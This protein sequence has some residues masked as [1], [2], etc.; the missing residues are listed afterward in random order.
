MSF[1]ITGS[2]AYDY[3]MFY[4]GRYRDHILMDQLDKISLSFLAESMRKERGGVAANIAYTMKL[5]GSDPIVLATV[6]QDFGDYRQ[7]MQE[8]GLRTDHIVEIEDEFTASF[9]VGSDQEQN[10]IAIFYTGAMAHA[11][12]YSL[13]SRGLHDAQIVMISPND[14]GAMLHYAQE[15]RRLGIP[16]AYD[17]S[18]QVPR[19]G[20]EELAQSIPGATYLL[21]NE[22]ELGVIQKKTGWSIDDIRSQVSVFVHTLGKE[23]SLIYS[24][25]LEIRIPAAR[26]DK[27]VDPTGAGDAYRGG[28]FAAVL[29]GL[30]W[31]VAGR[32]ASLC[33]AYA[34]E[35]RGTTT[36]RFSP[37]EFVAR[38]IQNFGRE[39][40]LDHLFGPA[41]AATP[42]AEDWRE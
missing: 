36:H 27:S 18:Q 9:F 16:Y 11:R 29:A 3:L 20:G 34:L 17:P 25:G 13:E 24:D 1:V 42:E 30:P 2:V 37:A 40:R 8:N 23:G 12:H 5:L 6:G 21:C 32:V 33:G 31:E 15:C 10:Q 39:P 14:P 41:L 35:Q 7:W 19:L 4:P 22:Y 38:Y 26:V 28:L